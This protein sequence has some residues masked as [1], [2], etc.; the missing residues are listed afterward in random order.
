MNVSSHKNID[1]KKDCVENTYD[2]LCK[3]HNECNMAKKAS[4]SDK[5]EGRC[6]LGTGSG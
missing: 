3:P 2:K 5:N 1:M 4:T 6:I